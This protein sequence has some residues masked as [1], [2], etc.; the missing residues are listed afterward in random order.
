MKKTLFFISFFLVALLAGAQQADVSYQVLQLPASA[1]VAA[2]GG[3]NITITEDNPSNAWS[4]PALLS[5][6]SDNSIS[7]NFMTYNS[8]SML[9]GAQFAKQFGARHSATVMAEYLG[10]GSMDETDENG[11]KLGSFSPKDI[12]I[13]FG[14]SYLLSERWTGGASLKMTS[15]SYGRYSS[16]GLSVDLGLN[17]YDEEKDLCLAVAMKNIG[18]QVKSFYEGQRTKMPF[19]L[20]LGFSKGMEHLPVRFHILLT[21]LTR[22][23]ESDYYHPSDKGKAGFGNILL[24]HFVLGLD[25]LP[26]DYLYLS[27]GYNFRRAYEL[28][29][30][31]SSK[32]AG[33]TFGAGLRLKKFK[34]GATYAK[35]HVGNAGVQFD[36]AYSF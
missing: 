8:G 23:S 12:V 7:L 24:N 18:A 29:S 3:D 9:F 1:H 34:F 11:V 15:Q 31:G 27:A 26:T 5:D 6:V 13:G 30:A 17:Y 4:N 36:I 16:F 14:Y 35:Y 22:W 25:I 32:L 10:Y 2:L 33:L 21:D 19:T 20:Q 28:K